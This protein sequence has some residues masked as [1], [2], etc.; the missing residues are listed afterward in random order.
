VENCTFEYCTGADK[1]GVFYLDLNTFHITLENVSFLYNFASSGI[2]GSDLFCGKADCMTQDVINRE[3]TCSTSKY[4]ILRN[5]VTGTNP[6]NPEFIP[7]CTTNPCNADIPDTCKEE[8]VSFLQHL[9]LFLFYL[10]MMVYAIMN[11][12][13]DMLQMKIE[14]ANLFARSQTQIWK[15]CVCLVYKI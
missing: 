1:G 8:C 13:L 12:L 5:S 9:F 4:S 7:L 2:N 11:V 14:N 10:D 3:N 6:K 15:I